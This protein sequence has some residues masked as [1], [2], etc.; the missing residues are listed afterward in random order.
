MFDPH[1]VGLATQ[2]E[3]AFLHRL[4]L[5]GQCT[6]PDSIPGYHE[7]YTS[8]A[9]RFLVAKPLSTVWWAAMISSRPGTALTCCAATS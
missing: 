1:I 7:D 2:Q 5:N 3:Q 6:V 8:A 4:T 9:L